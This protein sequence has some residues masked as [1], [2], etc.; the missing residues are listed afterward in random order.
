MRSLITSYLNPHLESPLDDLVVRTCGNERSLVDLMMGF[1]TADLLEDEVQALRPIAFERLSNRS[2]Q[3]VYLKVHDAAGPV[4]GGMPL[5]PAAA[6][7]RAVYVVR[8]PRDVCVSLA[9]FGPGRSLDRA[10]EILL[11]RDRWLAR[12]GNGR[13]DP[14]PQR[15]GSWPDHVQ[16]WSA[17][18]GFP[19]HTVRYEDLLERPHAT[20]STLL[21][22]LDVPGDAAAIARTVDTC[23]FE[24][25]AARETSV[26]F[27]EV[28][29][30]SSPFFRSG[31]RGSW[32]E[33]LTDGQA[34]RIEAA[35]GDLMRDLRY[36]EPEP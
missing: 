17:A 18:P 7:D 23:R 16:S 3:R 25:L 27:D 9:H 10:L 1:D 22:F 36:F 19:V 29:R 4:P 12:T 15:L 11:D 21:D 5:F 35:C 28:T 32:R 31:R 13:G 2:S 6:T 24:R 30:G 34:S 26:G 8:D 14:L 33:A 20:L